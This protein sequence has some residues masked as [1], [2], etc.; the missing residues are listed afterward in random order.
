MLSVHLRG[1][2]E[3]PVNYQPKI[4]DCLLSLFRQQGPD[5]F[6][7]AEE[8][9]GFTPGNQEFLGDIRE[10]LGR[11]LIR[12]I[13]G[14]DQHLAVQINQDRLDDIVNDVPSVPP[15]LLPSYDVFLSYTTDDK[16]LAAELRTAL[17]R[18]DLSCF[19]AEKDIPVAARF[20]ERIRAALTGSRKVVV[21]LTPRSKSRPW[22]LAEAGAA[23]ALG[24]GPILALVQLSFA[25]L[26]GPFAQYQA[27]QIDTA[28]QRNALVAEIA[29][30]LEQNVG[31]GT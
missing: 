6:V 3:R 7:L 16:G 28:R 23:W 13:S 29:T 31:D 21:L 26:D 4:L 1:S 2:G 22:I 14:P 18:K 27:R 20:E 24:K 25:D 8:L 12:G 11:G 9:P 19:M 5:A 15:D 30:T 10:L 17:K